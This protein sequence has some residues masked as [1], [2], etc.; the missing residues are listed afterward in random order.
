MAKDLFNRYIWLVDIIYR[1]KRITFEE[2]NERWMRTDMSEGREMPLRTFHNHRNAIEQ[3][4]DINIECDK[5]G[6]YC[7]YIENV[8]DMEEGG[9][10][11]W[12][13]NTFAVNN[14]I[15]ESHHL[16]RRILFENIPSGREFLTPIIEAMRDSVVIELTYQG[17]YRESPHAFEIEPY[18]VKVFNRR[19]YVVAYNRYY[20]EMRTY[21]LDRIQSLRATSE[22]YVM[23]SDF[24]PQDYFCYC[25]GIISDAECAIETVRIKADAH[26]RKYLLT[27]PLHHTQQQVESTPDYSILE[28]TLRPTLDFRQQLLSLGAE[29]EVLS[30]TWLRELMKKD[31]SA[32]LDSYI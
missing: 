25:F 31:I 18:C 28:Y 1:A 27:L 24:D 13:L 16:K 21:A 10:R 17:F 23:P 2:I 8:E 32:M 7:Y 22:S 9:V 19:W 14:L 6:G 20:K 12:L 15:N 29:L 26:L 5:R 4:F 3:M 30:P 11:S